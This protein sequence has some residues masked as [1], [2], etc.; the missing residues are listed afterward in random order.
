MGSN[1]SLRVCARGDKYDALTR[2]IIAEFFRYGGVTSYRD[3][4][5]F[6]TYGALGKKFITTQRLHT[7]L[8]LFRS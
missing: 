5:L 8:Q 1:S 6:R 7:G 4:H 3:T 2:K